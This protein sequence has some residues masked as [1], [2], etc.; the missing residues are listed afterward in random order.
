MWKMLVV[1]DDAATCRMIEEYLKAV[2]D[3][4]VR[5][6]T[7]EEQA[8]DSIQRN[9]YHIVLSDI[10]MPAIEGYSFLREL[11]KRDPLVHVIMMTAYSTLSRVILFL[12]EGA[13]D[14]VLKPFKGPDELLEVVNS[15]IHRWE[16]WV[17]VLKASAAGQ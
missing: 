10:V 17:K 8:L 3:L 13:L 2:P 16:R 1:D 14:F 7:N 11:K 5:T 4:D 9:K 12:G 15:S 6:F